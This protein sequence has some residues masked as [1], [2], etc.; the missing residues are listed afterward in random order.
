RT[1]AEERGLTVDEAG[2]ESAMEKQRAR[3]EEFAGSGERAVAT[4]YKTLREELGPTQFLGYETT[5]TEARVLALVV[6][7]KRVGSVAK[8]AKGVD[9]ITDRTPFYGE[10][11]GQVGDTGR[12]LVKGQVALGL[13]DT[14]KFDDLIVHVGSQASADLAVGDTI[15]LEVDRSRRD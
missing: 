12:I 13:T 11:G 3:S 7:G 4:I 6:D 10:A 9:V 15:E 2:F 1:I 14:K 5:Q 8:G